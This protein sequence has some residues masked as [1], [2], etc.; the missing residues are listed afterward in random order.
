MSPRPDTPAHSDIFPT[1]LNTLLYIF[2]LLIVVVEDGAPL[3]EL[4]AKFPFADG[5]GLGV[6][7]GLL[8]TGLVGH[9]DA[10]TDGLVLFPHEGIRL[11]GRKVL[12][13]TSVQVLHVAHRPVVAVLERLETVDHG[14]LEHLT[15]LGVDVALQLSGVEVVLH[16]GCRVG[17]GGGVVTAGPVLE[18]LRYRAPAE[19]VEASVLTASWRGVQGQCVRVHDAG[20]PGGRRRSPHHVARPDPRRLLVFLDLGTPRSLLRVLPLPLLLLVPFFAGRADPAAVAGLGSG[21]F[22]LFHGACL[23]IRLCGSRFSK[24]FAGFFHVGFRHAKH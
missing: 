4:H 10:E 12:R 18:L 7:V 15:G 14:R 3:V 11:D 5:A 9:G 23:Q 24:R 21:G 20:C 19:G 6:G 17:S 16:D 1:I 2:N 22:Y 13:F 8:P